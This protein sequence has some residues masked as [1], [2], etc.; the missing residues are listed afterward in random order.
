VNVPTPLAL[1]PDTVTTQDAIPEKLSV[2]V[3]VAAG[4]SPTVYA[5]PCTLTSAVV[6]VGFSRSMAIPPSVAV[7]E[8]PA[9]SVAVPLA[10]FVPLVESTTG[11]GQTATPDRPSEQVKVTVTGPSYQPLAVLL[12][13]VM[14]AVMIGAVLSSL[15]VTESVPMLPAP[16]FAVPV[17]TLPAVSVETVTGAVRLASPEP[18][19][20]S[21]A[22]NVTVTSRLFQSSALGVCDREWVTV[23]AMLSHF[24]ATLLTVSLLPAV[25]TA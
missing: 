25:S 23:G 20:S 11:S 14:A 24:R 9:R 15:T 12:P 19:S 7:A 1:P 4:T 2:A 18:A 13:A 6:S 16:S 17:T 3:Q 21:L 8:L 5:L 22:V 10:V